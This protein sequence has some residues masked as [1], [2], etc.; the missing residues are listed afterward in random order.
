MPT[1]ADELRAAAQKLRAAAS[2]A[3]PDICPEWTANAIRHV[4]RKGYIE[5]SHD[6][7]QDCPPDWDAYH[8]APYIALMDPDVG[9]ALADWL[10]HHAS[11][12]TA[13]TQYDPDSN[14]ARYA[15]AVA[16]ALNGDR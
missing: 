14:L 15:L 6:E 16:R 13:A 5:C 9:H 2:N 3:T 10:D 12:L 1:P 8:D 11:I 7:H 4:A